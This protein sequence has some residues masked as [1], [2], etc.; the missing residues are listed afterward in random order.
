MILETERLILRPWEDS[1]A[2]CLYEYAK[3]PQVGP[4]AGWLTHTSLDE[5]R[6]VIKGVLSAPETYAVVLKSLGHVVGSIGIMT[7]DRSNIKILDK[8][9]EIGFWIGRPFWGQGL[10]PEA[11]KEIVRYAFEELK[12]E[13]L[14][15][16]YSYDNEKSKRVQEK[17]GFKYHRTNKDVHWKLIDEIRTEHITCL[18]KE[19]YKHNPIPIER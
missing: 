2:E 11:L 15:C 10:I 6:E 18:S 19:D 4:K 17:C 14:W 3:D 8:E 1:D 9:G 13:K 12:L 7:S 16:V 5:S